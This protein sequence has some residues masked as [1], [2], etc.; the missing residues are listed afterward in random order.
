MQVRLAGVCARGDEQ[1]THSKGVLLGG[2]CKVQRSAAPVATKEASKQVRSCVGG[3][4]SAAQW[5]LLLLSA[6]TH[7]MFWALGLAPSCIN[8][9]MASWLPHSDA[10]CRAVCPI[11]NTAHPRGT[12]QGP[13]RE[14][15]TGANTH[16]H[17]THPPTLFA[18]LTGTPSCRTMAASSLALL[19]L[20]RARRKL[21][22]IL[23]T[24]ALSLG[25]CCCAVG[26][27]MLS[28]GRSWWVI[29]DWYS[30]TTDGLPGTI[31]FSPVQF[32][33]DQIRFRSVALKDAV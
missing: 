22:S 24:V 17:A 9:R 27:A 16:V 8:T 2:R 6:L 30:Q 1:L 5:L 20:A 12:Q 33:G 23:C 25:C 4:L 21:G 29:W 14:S 10:T 11:C 32:Y 19:S 28:L 13:G 3:C 15:P 26:C 7:L 31:P 18:V